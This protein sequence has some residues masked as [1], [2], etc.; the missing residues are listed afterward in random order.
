MTKITEDLIVCN[1]KI[2]TKEMYGMVTKNDQKVYLSQKS[3]L[4]LLILT[5]DCTLHA[6]TRNLMLKLSG[7]SHKCS[8]SAAI[9][10]IIFD[11][12]RVN[13]STHSIISIFHWVVFSSVQV[14]AILLVCCV[15]I[16]GHPYLVVF[17]GQKN[18]PK[19]YQYHIP[20]HPGKNKHSEFLKKDIWNRLIV[21]VKG[22]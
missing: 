4:G 16:L 18:N 8:Y 21:S 3:A 2:E 13:R 5:G 22:Y 11:R 7:R 17:P 15:A 10:R 1:R 20:Y 6:T 12:F 9:V 14:I 19:Y